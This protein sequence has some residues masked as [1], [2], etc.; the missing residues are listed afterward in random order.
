MIPFNKPLHTNRIQS[1]FDK[2]NQKAGDPVDDQQRW[3]FGIIADVN[4]EN[5]RIRVD[6]FERK[7]KKVRLGAGVDGEGDG[8]FIPI[9]QD[10]TDIHQ[11]FGR[12]RK[13]L[14]VKVYWKGKHF[15][16]S[17]SVAEVISDSPEAIF[18]SGRK[19]PRSNEVSTSSWRIF[20]GG[21][22]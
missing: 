4:E 21:V 5:S 16:T 8:A 13:G 6:F 10:I 3:S 19:E 12:L 17:D 2:T 22:T 11:R 1:G 14:L 9:L 18:A 20:L 15:P 7:G